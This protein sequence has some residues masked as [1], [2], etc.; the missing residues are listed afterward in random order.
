MIQ[1]LSVDF[2][3]IRL[4]MMLVIYAYVKNLTGHKI[5]MKMVL[6]NAILSFSVSMAEAIQSILMPLIIRS[7][8]TPEEIISLLDNI[9]YIQFGFSIV[10]IGFVAFVAFN[11]YKYKIIYYKLTFIYVG[12]LILFNPFI[13][14]L[15]VKDNLRLRAITAFVTLVIRTILLWSIYY[16]YSNKQFDLEMGLEKHMTYD[17]KVK[18]V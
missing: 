13:M 14:N 10:F 17:Y 1:Y 11:L 3:I 7:M 8:D 12:I 5:V 2:A 6:A 9:A 18:A 4:V 16:V 15:I